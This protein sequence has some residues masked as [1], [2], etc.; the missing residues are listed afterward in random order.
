[1]VVGN[2]DLNGNPVSSHSDANVEEGRTTIKVSLEKETIYLGAGIKRPVW[3]VYDG[4]SMAG[5]DFDHD[6]AHLRARDII[7]Q[8]THRDGA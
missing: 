2:V 7:E 4:N 8:R 5:W 3:I 6:A 1:V